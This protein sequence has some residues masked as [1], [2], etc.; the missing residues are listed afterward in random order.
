MDPEHPVPGVG[1]GVMLS[2]LGPET[3]D[4]ILDVGGP[5]SGSPLLSL[6]VR[7]LGGEIARPRPEHGALASIEAGYGLYAVGVAP[8]PEAAAAVRGHL[9]LL[10]ETLAPWTARH[11]YL[12][13]CDTRRDPATLWGEQAH[14][15]L[16]RIKEA[17]DPD[18]LIRSN[19]PV[20]A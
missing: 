18:G 3:I 10:K 16:G 13:F 9:E 17:V 4:A 7:Q 14:R 5:G 20:R 19:H 15:R 2:E 12:N 1:D 6:E 8:T 11:T